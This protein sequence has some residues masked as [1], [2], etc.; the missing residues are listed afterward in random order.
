VSA[1]VSETTSCLDMMLVEGKAKKFSQACGNWVEAE[2]CG[3]W[4]ES[5]R[6]VT[7][8]EYVESS[9]SSSS[10]WPGGEE[11]HR[12]DENS[13]QHTTTSREAENGVSRHRQNRL[14]KHSPDHR[15]ESARGTNRMW[16]TRHPARKI[17]TIM[18]GWSEN[19]IE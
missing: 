18:R 1:G 19:L 12:T 11:E 16:S 3:E 9:L 6:T 7:Y 17:C 15:E 14:E 13:R 10:S 5:G 4:T 8:Q 2:P